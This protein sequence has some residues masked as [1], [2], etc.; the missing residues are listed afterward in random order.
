M[1][2]LSVTFAS[3][4]SWSVSLAHYHHFPL[5]ACHWF[6]V[7]FP[8]RLIWYSV[9]P[10]H[11]IWTCYDSYVIWFEFV[12]KPFLY[13]YLENVLRKNHF[14]NDFYETDVIPLLY[15]GLMTFM[16]MAF[17]RILLWKQCLKDF[18]NFLNLFVLYLFLKD[19]S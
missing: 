18:H 8:F 5:F 3:L 9:F 15:E 12:L 17:K 2:F 19:L 11:L 13:M 16:K 4:L 14:K 1:I 10:F 6:V 7:R